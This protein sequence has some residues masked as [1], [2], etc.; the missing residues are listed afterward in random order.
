M[1]H[2]M[3]VEPR[4][5]RAAAWST[6][7]LGAVL[8]LTGCGGG[9][10]A[11]ESTSTLDE[12]KQAGKMVVGVRYDAPPYG[13]LGPDKKVEGF[14]VE[15]AHYIG[16]KLG[17]EVEFK[18]VTAE[19]R[20]TELQN[21]G[22]D[23]A[24]AAMAITHERQETVDFSLPYFRAYTRFLVKAGSGITGVADTA[25]KTVAVVAG[26]PYGEE[27]KRIEPE[28]K[29]RTLQEYPQAVEA[30]KSGQVDAILTGQDILFGLAKLDP[31]FEIV[32]E[33]D[34]FPPFD[35]GL[36]VRE[37]DSEWLDAINFALIEMYASGTYEE[38]H[39]QEFDQRPDPTFALPSWQ[40]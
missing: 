17:V 21:G 20:I 1:F 5:R 39:V 13:S 31:R 32:G 9:Q 30:L 26:T 3:T 11:S 24:A 34:A 7:T 36:G 4:S 28:A 18:Q 38:A 12:V 8:L 10:P 37:D 29:V 14:D 6:A 25:G 40:L 2:R 33:R 27:L 19:T 15:V 16:D 23:L 22:I 35:V